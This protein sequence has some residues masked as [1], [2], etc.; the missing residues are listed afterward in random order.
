MA[1]IAI[2]LGCFSGKNSWHLTYY[3]LFNVIIIID[4][5][6]AG[7]I[8][9]MLSE[10]IISQ[11]TPIYI[12]C[13]TTFI[14]FLVSTCET[15]ALVSFVRWMKWKMNKEKRRQSEMVSKQ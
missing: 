4:A 9:A 14:A 5:G 1:G 3:M 12:Q 6:T 15:I 2:A 13:A 11:V 10:N 8:A 7:Y